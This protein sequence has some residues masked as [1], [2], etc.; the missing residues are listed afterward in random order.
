MNQQTT[1]SGHPLFSPG[2]HRA[3]EEFL[4]KKPPARKVRLMTIGA[5]VIAQQG[6]QPPILFGISDRMI[7]TGDIEYQDNHPKILKL[8]HKTF[9][10]FAGDR[11]YHRMIVAAVQHKIPENGKPP[12]GVCE[13][14]DL[15]LSEFVKLRQKRAEAKWLLPLGLTY[16]T[17]H[18]LGAGANKD[19]LQE[20]LI[21]ERLGV[22]AIVA[23]MDSSG[24]H[25]FT[26]ARNDQEIPEVVCHDEAD[27]V[28]I[29]TGLRIF[30]SQFMLSGYTR[31]VGVLEALM[32]MF[33]A[34]KRAEVSPH[35]GSTTDSVIINTKNDEI[36]VVTPDM[37]EDL[38]RYYARLADGLDKAQTG[39]VRELALDPKWALAKTD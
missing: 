37:I 22:H 39:V 30:E 32:L 31:K 5:A 6:K 33:S 36:I 38:E 4:R 13:V 14:A 7:T 21:D 18:S 8:S 26:I 9:C 28:A 3:T 19:F 12:C 23:G 2:W 25:I 34:K 24:P 15:Y 10:L 20:R 16:A 29:G 27:Y 1:I 35:V 17:F 11:E